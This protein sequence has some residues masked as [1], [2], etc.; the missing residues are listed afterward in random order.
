MMEVPA[1]QPTT[2]KPISELFRAEAVAFWATTYNVDL[3]LFNEY[4]LERLGDPPLNAV[5]LADKHRLDKSLEAVPVERLDILSPVNRRWLLRG[6]QIGKGRFHPKSYLLVTARTAR[7][8]VGSGNLSTN[9][10]DAGREVFTTFVSGTPVGDAA[11]STWRA[12]MRRLIGGAD[13]TL[14]A[15]RYADLEERLPKPTGPALVAGTPLWHNLDTPL[16]EQFRDAVGSEEIDELIVTAPFFDEGGEALGRLI[17]WLKPK[18]V[19]LHTVSSTSVDGKQLAARL[20]ATTAD[21]EAFSYMPDR[22]TH[23]KLIGV[24]AGAHGWLLSGS[25]NLS[26]AGLTLRAGPGNVELAVFAELLAD[27]VHAAFIPPHTTAEAKSLAELGALTYSESEDEAAAVPPVR[28]VRATLLTGGRVRVVTTPGPEQGWRLA[29]HETVQPLIIEGVAAVTPG[30]LPGPLIHLVDSAGE[31]LSNHVVIDDL[32]ALAHAL[33]AGERVSSSRPS[34]LTI[35][36]LDTPLGTALTWLHQNIVM[37]VSERTTSGGVGGVRSD[38]VAEGSDD[39][40]LWD[41]L[42]RE[43]LARDP[44][45]GTYAR[46]LGEAGVI[47]V[48]DPLIELL[49]A[50]RHRV[51][52]QLGAPGSG[53]RSTLEQILHIDAAGG[54]HPWTPSARIRVRARN[55]LRRWAA[56]QTDPRLLWVDS[57][58]PLGNLNPDPPHDD[59]AT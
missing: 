14:L 12:W 24:T 44:R 38:E 30:E 29:D 58:A 59:P 36:D 11:I 45:A 13:D 10:I 42:E 40:S 3:A 55:V 25:A 7:L 53:V 33:E 16:A 28:I 52:T 6:V 15:E 23:A 1:T 32:D 26:R 46:L 50:M 20:A 17:D 48:A 8:L 41:R 43:K 35:G 19:R 22:F 39:D 18:V 27:A 51:P 9:G 47:G 56:A 31:T 49:D 34:E 5:I 21:V 54:G 2:I 57:L 37:D 4:L